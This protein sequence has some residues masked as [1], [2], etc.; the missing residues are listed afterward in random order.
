MGSQ[1]YGQVQATQ[2]RGATAFSRPVDPPQMVLG[3]V[4][5][6][7]LRG[8]A[9][10]ISPEVK[11]EGLSLGPHRLSSPLRE[12]ETLAAGATVPGLLVPVPPSLGPL[13]SGLCDHSPPSRVQR[14]IWVRRPLPRHGWDLAPSSHQRL[15]LVLRA[16]Q[17]ALWA[18]SRSCL[19]P[20]SW[21]GQ[22]NQ[23][24]QGPGVWAGQGRRSKRGRHFCNRQGVCAVSALWA[25]KSMQDGGSEAADLVGQCTRAVLP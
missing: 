12:S 22:G 9:E 1:R 10:R 21:R 6:P 17:K 2:E 13:A 15:V 3:L 24:V 19:P 5:L 18:V 4:L 8:S 25:G 7:R 16:Q 11:Q 23:T 14:Q 20:A